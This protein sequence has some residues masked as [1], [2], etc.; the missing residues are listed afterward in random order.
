MSLMRV[1]LPALL[2]VMAFGSAA[3]ARLARQQPA[4][5]A[6]AAPAS[7]VATCEPVTCCPRVIV[8]KNHPG[9]GCYDSC[10]RMEL[11]LQVK[12]PC[13]CCL[14]E[15]PTCIPACCTAAPTVCYHKGFLHRQVV[16]YSWACGFK[17]K[18]IFGKHGNV[19]VHY[20]G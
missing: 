20:F 9:C 7:K 10:K 2:V 12:D 18:M 19:A 11:I 17:I 5:P 8:Y 15:V 3:E 14:V 6:A 1:I 16:E 4:A 13:T